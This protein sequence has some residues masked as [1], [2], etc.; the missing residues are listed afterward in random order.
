MIY[1]PNSTNRV[2]IMS[3]ESLF[4]LLKRPWDPV[5]SSLNLDKPKKLPNNPVIV[6]VPSA[7]YSPNSSQFRRFHKWINLLSNLSSV[8]TVHI[9][10]II[11]ILKF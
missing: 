5:A 1:G 8:Q 9:G 4:V 11:L 10:N 3:N 2:G 6:V 7:L